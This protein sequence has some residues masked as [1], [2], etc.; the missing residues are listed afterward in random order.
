VQRN[1]IVKHNE[2]KKLKNMKKAVDFFKNI[3]YN[4]EK[5]KVPQFNILS[6]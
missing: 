6:A 2:I 1:N 4:K 5:S 3:K